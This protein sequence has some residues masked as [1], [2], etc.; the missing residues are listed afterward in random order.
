MPSRDIW[1][2]GSGTVLSDAI[3][4]LL[5]LILLR[6]DDPR[7]V[8]F[9]SPWI[10]DF[11]LFRN[12]FR[13]HA[14]LFPRLADENEI[15]L[16]D[17]LVRLAEDREVRV[18][19]SNNQYSQAFLADKKLAIR[20]INARLA[21]GP[22]H[23]KGILGPDVYLEGSMNITFKGVFINKEKVTLHSG[24]DRLT[25]AKIAAASFEFDSHWENLNVS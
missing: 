7:P 14:A 20:N 8:Y 3:G 19:A 16:S 1:S 13:E 21:Q 11:P 22:Y 10:T 25:L 9:S 15:W 2:P 17:Y 6:R 18:L 23:E 12:H 5:A 24:P 4:S